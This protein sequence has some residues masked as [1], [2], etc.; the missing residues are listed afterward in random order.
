MLVQQFGGVPLVLEVS[1]DIRADF[2]R[3][4]AA[5]V[6][7]A[8]IADLI[9]A[10]NNLAAIAPQLGRASSGAARDYLD[11]V[12][13][14]RGSAVSAEGKTERGAD[15]KDIDSTITYANAVIASNVY[16]LEPNYADLW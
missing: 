16:S 14:T 9:Y 12:Y 2:P 6:Y 11:K 1:R 8:I 3:A 5:E 15:A 13:L 10:K 7:Q 4:T